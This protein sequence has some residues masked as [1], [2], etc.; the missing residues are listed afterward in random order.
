MTEIRTI[1]IDRN[2]AHSA[3]NKMR[4]YAIAT[5]LFVLLFSLAVRAVWQYRAGSAPR[6]TL[7]LSM[8]G[9][10]RRDSDRIGTDALSR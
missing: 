8:D 10:G 9:F 5:I 4:W 7:P 3:S 2:P 6:G 1:K